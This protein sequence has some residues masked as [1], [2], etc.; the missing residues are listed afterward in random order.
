VSARLVV[1]LVFSLA[2]NISGLL[3]LD[4]LNARPRPAPEALAAEVRAIDFLVPPP[5]RSRERRPTRPPRQEAAIEPLPAALANLP[6]MIGARHLSGP[7]L[8]AA[9]IIRPVDVEELPALGRLIMSEET[10][11]RPPRATRRVRA[12]YP[13]DAEAAGTEGS[14]TFRLLVDREGRVESIR[15]ERSEPLGVFDSAARRAVARW[16]FAPAIFAG[17]PVAAWC[18]VTL[19]FELGQV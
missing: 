4:R 7:P 16:R 18:R 17:R 1:A 10:V 11:D 6:S 9:G 5:Q 14:V 3:L 2:I 19:I 13:V 12:E 15:I 8:N